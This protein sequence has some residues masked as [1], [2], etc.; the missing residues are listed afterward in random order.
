MSWPSGRCERRGSGVAT[1]RH[2]PGASVKFV[3]C[4][5]GSATGWPTAEWHDGLFSLLFLLGG[6]VAVAQKHGANERPNEEKSDTERGRNER[7]RHG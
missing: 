6:K 1:F 2:D 7:E 3:R 4:L 5:G